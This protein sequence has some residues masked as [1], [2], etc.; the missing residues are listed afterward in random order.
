MPADLADGALGVGEA[1]GV[2]F[3]RGVRQSC[4][5][6][7]WFRALPIPPWVIPTSAA[8]GLVMIVAAGTVFPALAVRIPADYF[9]VPRPPRQS[10]RHPLL[11]VLIHVV[12]NML[13]LLLLAAGVIMLFTPGQGVWTILAA[14]MVSVFPG[15]YGLERWL[16]TRGP[17]WR[18]LQWMRRKRHVAPL[19]RP[20]KK[21]PQGESDA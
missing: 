1:G 11:I 20:P 21:S 17:V 9:A 13:A 6:I 2:D 3:R 12:R 7:E 18:S 19:I 8:V 4:G 5:M 15:K 10:R 16:A 14:L